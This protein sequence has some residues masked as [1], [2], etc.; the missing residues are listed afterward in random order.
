MSG[1]RL[2]RAAA[3]VVLVVLE[4][5]LVVVVVVVVHFIRVFLPAA[6]DFSLCGTF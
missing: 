1:V 4:V 2:H 3:A 5:L 6:V